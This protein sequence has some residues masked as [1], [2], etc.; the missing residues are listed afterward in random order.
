MAKGISGPGEIHRRIIAVMKR[1]P[2]GISAAQVRHEL[3]RQGIPREDLGDLVQRITELDNW[4]LI[5]T[6]TT[7][8]PVEDDTPLIADV[9]QIAQAPRAAVLYAARGRCQSCRKTIRADSITL[10]VRSKA[11]GNLNDAVHRDNL[12]AICE[13]CDAGNSSRRPRPMIIGAR[14]KFKSCCRISDSTRS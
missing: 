7:V 2:D 6:R 14:P 9:E 4:F 8:W 12:W 13:N 11:T 1:F 5:E 3:E 10:V